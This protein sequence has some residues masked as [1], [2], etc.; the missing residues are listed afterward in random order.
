MVTGLSSSRR[1]SSSDRREDA[2]VTDYPVFPIF[3]E[4]IE[5]RHRDAL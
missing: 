2:P 3:I 5:V 4:A 1:R